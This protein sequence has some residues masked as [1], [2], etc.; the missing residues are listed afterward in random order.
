MK[1]IIHKERN[2]IGVCSVGG[3]GICEACLVRISGKLY[4]KATLIN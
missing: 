2:A 1:C 4:C 3:Q